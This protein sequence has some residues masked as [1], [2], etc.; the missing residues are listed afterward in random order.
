MSNPGE[1]RARRIP[2]QP[3]RRWARADPWPP[4]SLATW[5]LPRRADAPRA[6]TRGPVVARRC[7][8][9]A[10]L[11]RSATASG[12]HQG[13]VHCVGRTAAPPAAGRFSP[14][15]RPPFLRGSGRVAV[16]E[17]RREQ[18]PIS[19]GRMSWE[20]AA[21]PR[22]RV[23]ETRLGRVHTSGPTAIRRYFSASLASSENQHTPDHLFGSLAGHEKLL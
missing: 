23:R 6:P 1:L 9:R 4:P 21:R 20:L 7:R 16:G 15:E 5:G 17:S 13:P 3:Q 22:D 10:P 18:V 19:A 2:F 14:S 11:P 12:C 8:T